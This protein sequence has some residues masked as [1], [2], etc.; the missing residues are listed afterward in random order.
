MGDSFQFYLDL[1]LIWL[2]LID[3][4]VLAANVINRYTKEPS[5]YGERSFMKYCVAALVALFVAVVLYSTLHPEVRRPIIG[6]EQFFSLLDKSVPVSHLTITLAAICC[7]LI[8]FARLVKKLQRSQLK[9]RATRD[10]Q[11]KKIKSLEA[12][13]RILKSQLKSN[14]RKLKAL[15][16]LA[17]KYGISI[18]EIDEEIKKNRETKKANNFLTLKAQNRTLINFFHS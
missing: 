17:E 9:E 8:P 4:C 18:N 10:Y 7:A 12:N 1:L 6:I 5:R 3:V 16:Y 13:V 11:A 2:L 15:E 14:N